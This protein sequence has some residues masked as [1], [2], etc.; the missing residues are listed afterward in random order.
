[1]EEELKPE[2]AVGAEA[3]RTRNTGTVS[4]EEFSADGWNELQSFPAGTTTAQAA[5]WLHE[6]VENGRSPGRFRI[7]RIMETMLCSVETK[8]AVTWEAG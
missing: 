7:I 6:L 2:V 5:K 3:A 4:V 8:R 1:M